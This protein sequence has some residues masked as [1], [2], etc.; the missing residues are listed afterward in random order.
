MQLINQTKTNAIKIV[1][2]TIILGITVNILSAEAYA[3]IC[4]IHWND[5]SSWMYTLV[6]TGSPTC[7]WLSYVN[8]MTHL[9]TF[10]FM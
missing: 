6:L 10:N 9:N 3:Q 7:K 1:G 4:K 8:Y 2:C 5:P